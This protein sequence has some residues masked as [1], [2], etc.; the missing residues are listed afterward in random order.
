MDSFGRI[1][2]KQPDSNG[3]NSTPAAAVKLRRINMENRDMR[4]FYLKSFLVFS[5]ALSAVFAVQSAACFV[6]FAVLSTA[7]SPQ[8]DVFSAAFSI[9]LFCDSL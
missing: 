1:K 4:G 5:A 2:R 8:L 6:A 7:F 3:M 9:L